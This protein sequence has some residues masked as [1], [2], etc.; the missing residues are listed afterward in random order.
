MESN[1][2]QRTLVLL[3]E[4]SCAYG[5]IGFSELLE[6]IQVAQWL[7]GD[8]SVSDPRIERAEGE[9]EKAPT[10]EEP[11]Q[12]A[13]PNAEQTMSSSNTGGTANDDPPVLP[14]VVLGQ[15]WYFTGSDPDFYPSVPHGHFQ[16]ATRKWPKLNPYTGRV[17]SAKRQEDT[18]MRLKRTEMR[19]IWQDHKFRDFCRS[20]V[21]WYLTE[22]PHY[23][24]SV[25]HPLRFPRWYG[26]GAGRGGKAMGA[27]F[28][29]GR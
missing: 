25:A 24:F 19:Q 1:M 28:G 6:R 5:L 11:E 7:Y 12:D 27:G 29:G 3:A 17:F 18:G 23:N 4:V 16:C 9:V 2:E 10:E 26:H 22:H 8:P 21:T 14:L 13:V 20:N 15:N